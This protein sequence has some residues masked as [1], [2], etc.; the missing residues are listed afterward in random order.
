MLKYLRCFLR[1]VM[2]KITFENW[3]RNTK[4]NKLLQPI[5]PGFDFSSNHRIIV[6]KQLEL[7]F[8][9]LD[10]EDPIFVILFLWFFS[11]KIRTLLKQVYKRGELAGS[12]GAGRYFPF[13]WI[14]KPKSWI[15]N[16]L[17][18]YFYYIFGDSVRGYI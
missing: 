4:K 6:Y 1:I 11:Y 16:I 10:K 7:S 13:L 18:H 5:E 12:S 17:K 2:G 15:C 14:F 3:L 8:S 9:L